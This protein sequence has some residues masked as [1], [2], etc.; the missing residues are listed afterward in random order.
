[1][2]VLF[3]VIGHGAKVA[4]SLRPDGLVARLRNFI[5]HFLVY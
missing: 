2:S 1:M 4:C 3:M 5:N